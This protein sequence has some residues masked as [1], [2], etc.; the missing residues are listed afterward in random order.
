MGAIAFGHVAVLAKENLLCE[1]F[2]VFY[3]NV[4]VFRW[5]K[6]VEIV[7]VKDSIFGIMTTIYKFLMNFPAY[8]AHV[9]ILT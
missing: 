9:A 5:G 7:V 6:V 4:A 1:L 8:R 2:R 3:K